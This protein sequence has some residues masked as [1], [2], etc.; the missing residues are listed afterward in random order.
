MSLFSPHIRN[1][2]LQFRAGKMTKQGTTVTGDPRSGIFALVQQPSGAL[3]VHWM[4]EGQ[5]QQEEVRTVIG[6]NV[7]VS[8]APK[9]TTGRV[10][11]I[12]FGPD[13]LFYWLQERND[14]R[15]EEY[16]KTLKKHIE[17]PAPGGGASS[18]ASGS[19]GAA[20][21]GRAAGATA[22]GAPSIGMSTL[23]NILSSLGGPAS[24]APASGS[25][26]GA[27]SSTPVGASTADL[28]SNLDLQRLLLSPQLLEAIRR[29]PAFYMTR[30]HEHL[31]AGTDP[32]DD[33][34]PHVRNPQISGAASMLQ[35]ALSEP[36]A[37]R[38]VANAFGVNTSG[39]GVPGAL[40]FVQ[41]I[42]QEPKKDAPEG[43]NAQASL[44]S[45]PQQ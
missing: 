44:Q 42:N 30:L 35:A 11:V 33:I 31:P 17:R 25:Q 38:E 3:E 43:G 41:R 5:P 4:P 22:A 1:A 6:N 34:V 45:P 12:D 37:F 21:G 36:E 18:A 32:S 19:S 27:S 14:E 20:A 13:Q 28:G 29:D 15:D 10:M 7:K 40:A 16:L 26:A 9:C 24:P 8:R 39:V 23:Q 2:I